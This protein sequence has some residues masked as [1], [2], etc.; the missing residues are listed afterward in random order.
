MDRLIDI[1]CQKQHIED[2]VVL[3]HASLLIFQGIRSQEVHQLVY[4]EN[5]HEKSDENY[6]QPH[7][8]TGKIRLFLIW[9][10][11]GF[12][13]EYLFTLSWRSPVNWKIFI[14]YVGLYLATIM[15]YWWPLGE[16]N[17]PLK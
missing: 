10:V 17:K 14:P 1:G 4:A 11:F 6:G 3:C 15:F 8:Q 13:V 12:L 16:I 7:P 9:A 5:L 2:W